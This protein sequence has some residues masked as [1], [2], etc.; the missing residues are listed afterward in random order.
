MGEIEEIKNKLEDHEKRIAKLE[1]RPRKKISVEQHSGLN[2]GINL[3]IKNDFLDSP[4]KFSDIFSEL[5]REGY[6]YGKGAVAKALSVYF[7]N[8]MKI[9]TRYKENDQWYYAVR[10]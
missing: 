3:L 8:K 4:K 1:N 9:L 10:K 6:H 5:K 7:V 2:G